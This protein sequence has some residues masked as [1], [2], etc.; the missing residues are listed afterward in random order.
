L[1]EFNSLNHLDQLDTIRRL[2]REIHDRRTT[3]ERHAAIA[4][5]LLKFEIV[6]PVGVSPGAKKH[7]MA[8]NNSRPVTSYATSQPQKNSL[9]PYDD[10][11]VSKSITKCL[12]NKQKISKFSRKFLKSLKKISPKLKKSNIQIHTQNQNRSIR[13]EVINDFPNHQRKVSKFKTRELPSGS[14]YFLTILENKIFLRK[15]NEA[16]FSLVFHPHRVCT[17]TPLDKQPPSYEEKENVFKHKNRNVIGKIKI[18]HE[19]RGQPQ[20]QPDLRKL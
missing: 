17:S 7:A 13:K 20:P 3:N 9:K 5:F 4:A 19:L 16:D 1:R 18:K 14:V 6:E 15:C 8:S 11:T 2:D 12:K 10:F